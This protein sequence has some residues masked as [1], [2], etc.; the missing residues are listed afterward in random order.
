MD[1]D[2][3]KTNKEKPKKSD[4]KAFLKKRAPIYLGL[5]GLFVIFVIP[6]LTKND[7]QNS[8]PDNLTEN[9]KQTVEI[10]MSYSGPNKKG[11]TVMNAVMEQIAAEYPNEKI[12]DNKKTKVELVVSSLDEFQNMQQVVLIFKSY[13]GDLEYVWNVNTDTKEIKANNSNAKHIVDIVDY[14]D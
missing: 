11:L 7:L 3:K 4:F 5:I 12:Y 10:L 1:K 9:Q 6:E 8:F 14:Y 13:K 2:N